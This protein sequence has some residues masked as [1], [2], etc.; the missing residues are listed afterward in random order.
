M[1]QGNE[2]AVSG[3][4]GWLY[5]TPGLD[6]LTGQPFLASGQLEKREESHEIWEKPL[7]PDPLKA[8]INFKEQ[9]GRR[10]IEL[11]VVPVPTKG[12]IEPEKLSVRSVEKSLVNRSWPTFVKSLEEHG[13]LLFDARPLLVDYSLRSGAGFLR[14]DTHWLPGAMQVVAEGLAQYI[15]DRVP[16]IKGTTIFTVQKQ[17]VT[18]EGDIARMLTLPEKT[19]IFQAQQVEINQVLT[20]QNEFWQPD[21]N[22]EILVL[23]D[24]FTN[25]YS[26]KGLGWGFGAGF[27]E[28]L[29]HALRQPLDLLTRNDSGAYVTREM[30]AAELRRGRDRLA[31]KKLV[32]WQFA[33]RELALGDWKLI[34]LTLGE[35]KESGFHLVHQGEK[36]QVTAQV[37]AISRSPRPG[38]VPYRDNLITLH[39]L[40]LKVEGRAL[41]SGQVLVY[42]WGMKD[43]QLT[44]MAAYRPGDTISLTLSSWDDVEG[45]FGSYRRTPLDDEM[46]ELELPN[47]GTLSDDKTN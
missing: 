14:T 43:N 38:S 15:E 5:F 9:L 46:M 16:G 45:D 29:S 3:R 17:V 31:G 35:E 2:K 26:L 13:I 6:Y 19:S 7:Q 36:L 27:A 1:G 21:R 10:G 11:I 22:G 32:I 37:G 23:G 40:D 30:L 8:I 39:L 28:H 12:A 18:A 47:W 24:S 34:D 41:E 33:E 42:A 25:I 44:E 4:D 20:E